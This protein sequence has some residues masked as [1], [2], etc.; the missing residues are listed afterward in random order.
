[1]GT[2][3]RLLDIPCKVCGDRSSGKHYGIYSCDGCSGF[4]K[5][6]IHRNRVYTCKAQG[7]LK[8]RCPIDKTH[9]N[10]CRACR[11]TKCFQSA[12]NKDAVQ[13]E[14]GPRKPKQSKDGESPVRQVSGNN[15]VCLESSQHSPLKLTSPAYQQAPM[16]QADSPE[17]RPQPLFVSHQPPGLLQ[18][19]MSAEKCQEIV[20]NGK[21]DV[22]NGGNSGP[23][24]PSATAIPLSL[25]PSWEVLQETTARLLFMAVRWVRCLAPFQ[26]LSKRDQLL[27]L[28]ESWKE[29]FLLHLAQWSIPWDLSPVLGGPKA[30]ERLPLDDTL[31]PN[32]LNA[33]QEILARFRQLSPDGSEC[34]CM[35]AVILFTPET[36][37]LVDVQPVE[38]LQD[39]A[40]CILN[41][42]VRG[43]YAR[44]PTR[45]GRLLLMIPGLKVIR[46]STIERLFFRETIGDIPI[47][48]LLGDM[49]VM[50]KSYS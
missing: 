44:Q 32:E 43:R 19:L 35:K 31:V 2:G 14:R 38:M 26:T 27:L 24:S 42:Y 3:D 23:G 30:R 29:L 8:G 20:W 10:Q 21:L 5:R 40:Q 22:I 47:H 11:L 25:S 50:E 46:Q 12:M 4:F 33:I 6:S 15:G 34:G 7:D 41:D 49:Y 37:G 17:R 9:R 13:H 39:Q 28:Q 48:R 36:P 45:F 18:L 1:M 16:Q